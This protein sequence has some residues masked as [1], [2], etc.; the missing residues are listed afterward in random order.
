MGVQIK[1]DEMGEACAM[2]IYRLPGK[3]NLWGIGM[4]AKMVVN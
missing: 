2:M 3:S 4:G 1:K